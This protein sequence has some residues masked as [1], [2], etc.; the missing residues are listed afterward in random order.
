[1][2]AGAAEGGALSRSELEKIVLDRRLL[3]RQVWRLFY[4]WMILQCVVAQVSFAADGKTTVAD[5]IYRADGTPA[6]GTVIIS[7]QSFT[8]GDNRPVAAGTLSRAIG[9][10]GS[11]SADL[12]PTPSGVFYKVVVKEVGGTTSTE[13]WNVPASSPTTIAAVRTKVVP[14]NVA[15]Q[16]ASRTELVARALDSAVVHN[17]GSEQIGGSKTFLQSPLVP[18]PVSAG[19]AAPKSYVDTAVSQLAGSFLTADSAQPV[20]LNA[21]RYADK[22]ASVQAAV[23]DA[24]TTG[25]VV[26][27]PNYTDP[28]P[29]TNPNKIPIQDLRQ[30]TVREID[31]RKHGARLDARLV[32]DCSFATGSPILTCTGASWTT[33]DVGKLINVY[34]STVSGLTPFRATISARTSATQVT[35]SVNSP[36]TN[37]ASGYA[38]YGTNDAPAIQA[39]IDETGETVSHKFYGGRL[40]IPGCAMIASQLTALNKAGL[41]IDGLGWGLVSTTNPGPGSCLIWSGTTSESMVQFKNSTGSGIRNIHL[42]GLSGS[43]PL[44]CIHLNQVNT[45]GHPNSKILVDNVFCGSMGGFDPDN[46]TKQFQN[47]IYASG[48]G[49]NNDQH[50]FNRFNGFGADTCVNM[51]DAQSTDNRWTDLFIG[52]CDTGFTAVGRHELFNAFFSTNLVDFRP[53]TGAR[54]NLHGFGSEGSGRMGVLDY[55]G[56]VWTLKGGAWQAGPNLAPDGHYIEVN[57]TGGIIDFENFNL[58]KNSPAVPP[59]LYRAGGTTF[60]VRMNN[61]GSMNPDNY[62]ITVGGGGNQFAFL[63]GWYRSTNQGFPTFYRN[64]LTAGQTFDAF[65]YDL[66]NKVNVTGSLTV[67]QLT[68]PAASACFPTGGSGTTYSY[69]VRGVSNGRE[70]AVSSA[71]T[72]SGGA[73]LGGGVTNKVRWATV[74]GADQYRL[75]GRQTGTE[76]LIATINAKDYLAAGTDLVEYVDDGSVTP[77]GAPDVTNSS[78]A[79]SIEGPL[80]VGSGTPIRKHL[81]TTASVDFAAWAG[82]DCQEKTISMTGVADGDAVTAGIPNAL[83]SIAGVVWS[84]PW[85]SGTNVLSIRACKITSGA[86]ADPAPATVRV[87]AWLH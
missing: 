41:M 3:S 1:M 78:G 54:F 66:W 82:N 59:V 28:S 69:R 24:G 13:Y 5:T 17:T 55:G 29:F 22:F 34:G 47:L 86:S 44:A 80:T 51:P 61:T 14:A 16:F 48:Y 77:S 36:I 42:I 25:V 27:P 73:A 7:W 49:A 40:V 87:D 32:S 19:A 74:I 4:F 70:G 63:D 11:F 60:T 52:Q 65:R 38:I 53:L 81:S 35:L 18:V 12:Y 15:A 10:G 58:S 20:R 64:M 23:T 43:K 21:V 71:F 79:A 6:S 67:R 72:C 31:V 56:V 26:I 85:V 50:S 8:T 83:A 45:E 37:A 30:T 39:A 33:T 2:V 84:H 9:Q 62:A 68:A 76:Q 46:G 57:T 75:Y